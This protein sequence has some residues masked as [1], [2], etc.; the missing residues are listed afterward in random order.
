MKEEL[1]KLGERIRVHRRRKKWT[2][3]ELANEIGYSMNGVA[4]IERG[5]SDPKYSALVK[6]A[7]ALGTNVESLVGDRVAYTAELS[8]ISNE[9]MLRIALDVLQSTK[10][11]TDHI[12]E[13]NAEI[14]RRGIEHLVVEQETKSD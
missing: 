2:Q 4:K 10:A 1:V 3:T 7:T 12:D 8:G 5:E 9:G 14:I 13:T 11:L 6:M